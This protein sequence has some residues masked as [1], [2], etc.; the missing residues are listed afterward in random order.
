MEQAEQWLFMKCRGVESGTT[1]HEFI[2]WER[3]GFE[4]GT[5]RLQINPPSHQDTLPPL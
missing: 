5:S 2:Q 1:K 4:L 3:G